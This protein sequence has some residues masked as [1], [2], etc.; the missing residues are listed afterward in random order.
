MIHVNQSSTTLFGGH[1]KKECSGF[2]NYRG[3]LYQPNQCIF[4]GK[5]LKNFPYNLPQV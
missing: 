2:S 4:K 5:T 3:S 1:I